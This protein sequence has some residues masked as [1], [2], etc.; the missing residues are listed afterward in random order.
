MPD[1]I[2]SFSMYQVAVELMS[3]NSYCTQNAGNAQTVISPILSGGAG[4][5]LFVLNNT[6]LCVETETM[7]PL[8]F[9]K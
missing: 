7:G 8:W 5:G 3:K 1:G 4:P 6:E 9:I 2:F